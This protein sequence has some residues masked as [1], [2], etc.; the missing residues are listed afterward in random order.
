[1]V[2]VREECALSWAHLSS[3]PLVPT[4]LRLLARRMSVL[5]ALLTVIAPSLRAQAIVPGRSPHA[6]IQ[7]WMAAY[8][9]PDSAAMVA[10]YAPTALVMPPG[11]TLM[12]GLDAVRGRLAD[13]LVPAEMVLVVT[14]SA[15]RGDLHVS[16]GR[17]TARRQGDTGPGRDGTWVFVMRRQPDGRWRITLN[18]WGFVRAR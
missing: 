4:M 1:M 3:L 17:F 6:T 12:R 15:T 8:N 5:A 14:D 18:Q 9:R 11:D 10:L 16:A 2:P 13:G 7:A